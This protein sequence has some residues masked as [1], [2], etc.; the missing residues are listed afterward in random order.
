VRYLV[1]LETPA[2]GTVCPA[3]HKPFE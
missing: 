1:D 3:D 2:P